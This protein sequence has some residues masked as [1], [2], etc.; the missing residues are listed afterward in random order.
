MRYE[1]G[2]IQ[3]SE[4]ADLPILR[5]VYHA[6]HLTTRQLYESVYT[7][8]GEKMWNSFKWRVRRLAQHEFLDRTRVDGIGAVFSLG[9][10]GELCLQGKE[11]TI[12]ERSS[13]T[14]L[15]KPKGSDL[16]R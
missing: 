12:V 4:R 1:R 16:A 6:G 14:K 3:I 5:L 15:G 10:N 11:P 8:L 9:I 7:A 13:R 2:L